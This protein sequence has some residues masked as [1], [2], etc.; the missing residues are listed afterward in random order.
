MLFQTAG[1]V[2]LT[3][4]V[5]GIT[6]R[7]L[8]KALKLT[9]VSLGRREDMHHAVLAIEEIKI[10]TMKMFKLSEKLE[11]ADWKIVNNFCTIEN[12]YQN[13]VSSL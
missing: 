9:E 7:P 8:L 4:L 1:I 10:E 6:T 5:N 13:D 12:P 11:D 3:L 2:I